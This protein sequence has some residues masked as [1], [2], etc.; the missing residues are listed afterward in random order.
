V[1]LS[2]VQDQDLKWMTKT[3]AQGIKTKI[4]G[5]STKTKTLRIES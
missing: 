4:G 3:K 1:L 5:L 2:Q